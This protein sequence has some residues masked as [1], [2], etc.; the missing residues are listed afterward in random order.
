MAGCF[1]N[2]SSITFRDSLSS[3]LLYLLPSPSLSFCANISRAFIRKTPVSVLETS[4]IQRLGKNELLRLSVTE[5]LKNRE[6]PY[7]NASWI[8]H[9]QQ[10]AS[11]YVRFSIL[12]GT[13]FANKDGV[14]P[15]KEA[16]QSAISTRQRKIF[17][18]HYVV[19]TTQVS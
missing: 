18:R 11:T 13:F 4:I 6:I 19:N 14:I 16:R 5:Y 7:S 3:Q 2:E 9:Q 15:C 1:R 12:V 17:E 8:S 10:Q